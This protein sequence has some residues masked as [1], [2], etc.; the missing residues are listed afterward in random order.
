VLTAVNGTYYTEMFL[1][2]LLVAILRKRRQLLHQ[3]VI[4]FQ[5]NATPHPQSDVQAFSA[6][7]GLENSREYFELSRPCTLRLIFP[8]R[9]EV[10]E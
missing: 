2:K 4:L 6:G 8:P 7:M 9:Q 5:E 3:S 10:N 1:D